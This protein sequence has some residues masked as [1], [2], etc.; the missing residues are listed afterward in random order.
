MKSFPP[1]QAHD[2]LTSTARSSVS[3]AP[4]VQRPSG[5][6]SPPVGSPTRRRGSRPCSLPRRLGGR[7]SQA[8]TSLLPRNQASFYFKA[9]ATLICVLCFLSHGGCLLLWWSCGDVA[10]VPHDEDGCR[11][12][13]ES[14]WPIHGAKEFGRP[15]GTPCHRPSPPAGPP[16]LHPLASIHWPHPSRPP[17][18]QPVPTAVPRCFYCYH[19][20]PSRN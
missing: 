10:G 8:P 7:T 4:A 9:R 15:Q 13:L 18:S 12:L 17:L 2:Q 20:I 1:N 11:Y 16:S 19:S 14:A 3:W 5:S 6:S